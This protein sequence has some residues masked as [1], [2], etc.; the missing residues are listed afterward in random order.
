MSSEYETRRTSW[1]TA[2]VEDVQISSPEKISTRRIAKPE[3]VDNAKDPAACVKV[4]LMHQK[5]HDAKAPWQ[6]ADS[7][8]LTSL[9]KGEEVKLALSCGETRRL[10]VALRDLYTIGTDGLPE[11]ERSLAVVDTEDAYVA[12]GKE[13]E[14]IQGLLEREGEQFF[15]VVNE[16]QPDLFTAAAGRKQSSSE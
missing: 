1:A 6:D 12:T 16:L 9:K 10:F 13:K 5:R 7:F 8:N 2:R 15:D 14:L 3:L 4:T 11:G